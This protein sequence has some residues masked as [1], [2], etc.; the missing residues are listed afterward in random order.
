MSKQIKRYSDRTIVEHI[1]TQYVLGTLCTRVHNRAEKLLIDY[2]LLQSRVNYWQNNLS[3]LD[4][5]TPELS[6]KES[7]WQAISA[8]IDNLETDT[9]TSNIQPIKSEQKKS[10][11]EYNKPSV[12]DVFSRI[13]NWLPLPNQK[14]AHAFSVIVISILSLA[15]LTSNTE[16]NSNDPLSYV[17][18][19][20]N[21]NQQAQLVA[22]TY[23]A[24]K[25]LILN[26]ID[27]PKIDKTED[28]ELWVVSKTDNEARSLGTIPR[29]INLFEQQLTEAQ[30]RLIKYSGSLI[31]T[32]E[33]I[34]GSPIGEPSDTIVSR[35][36][37]V[38]LKEWNKNV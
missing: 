21:Q 35:G 23:G 7:S 15:L 25:K 19:L 4:K 37:C 24:S 30:W 10:N 20:T 12:M 11:K 26:I 38:R 16:E 22:S 5:L 32:I 31:V 14:L 9:I 29:D 8:C 6:P 28:L 33:D 34:G 1:A 18:V 13:L 3:S 36:L 2:P 27:I 17:A